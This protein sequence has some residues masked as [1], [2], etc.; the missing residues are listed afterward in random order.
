MTFSHLPSKIVVLRHPEC[1][2]NVAHQEALEQGIENRFSP[3]TAAGEAQRDITAQYLSETHGQFD[4]VFAST[5]IRTHT[6]PAQAR[7]A[8]IASH[9]LDERNMGVWHTLPRRRVLEHYPGEEERLREIGYYHYK[10]PEGESCEEVEER[11][12]TFLQHEPHFK[13]IDSMLISGHG[14]TGLCFRKI[15]L[16]GTVKDWYS[17]Q[18]LKNASVTVYEKGANGF[19][20]TLYNHIPWD[21]LVD[22]EQGVEA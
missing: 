21:G 13:D 15:L 19:E 5:F 1:L 22:T 18:R 17:W 3:L 12:L 9:L 6:I 10:A 11:I 14:I 8:M 7:F 2:H 20:C 16:G 4:A